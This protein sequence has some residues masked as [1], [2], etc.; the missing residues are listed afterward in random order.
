MIRS[1]YSSSAGMRAQQ[2]SVDV[3]A[4]NL[5]NVNT[6]G[7]KRSQAQFRDLLYVTMRQ[8][9][10]TSSEDSS[11]S[12]G[13]EIGSGAEVVA[14]TKLFSQGVHEPTENPY[15]IAIDGDGFFEV[16][17]P[18][19]ERAY[20]RNGTFRLNSDRRL[21]TPD[22]H[23]LQPAVDIPQDATQVAIAPDGTVSVVTATDPTAR[24]VTQLTLMR[25]VNPA[26]LQ[27]EGN[28]LYRQTEGSGPPTPFTP[29]QDGTGLLRQGFLE[30]SN[31]DV[32][33]EMIALIA[34]QR[35]YEVNSRAI[36]SSD[37]MLQ[38]VT[39]LVQ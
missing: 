30:R 22:G 20:T 2:L 25:F 32:V 6:V 5:A 31:V 21:V 4:N 15:D 39:G 33:T 3:I 23:V 26:G 36:R 29:G 18:N 19:G 9:G 7:F 37:E 14:T 34:A 17:L 24:V 27:S 35:A 1:L 38:Q 11:N 16:E 13:L 28:N 10:A 12:L 8:P